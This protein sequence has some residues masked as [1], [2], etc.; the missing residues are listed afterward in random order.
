MASQKLG[1]WE[2]TDEEIE[3][4]LKASAKAGEA[5][6]DR[7][8][9]N[10]K[11]SANG[12]QVTLYFPDDLVLSFPSSDIKELADADPVEIRKGYLTE[13]GDA[14]H[15]DNL[16]AHYTVIGLLMG[17]FGPREW[18][19]EL[20][21]RGG[22]KT[23]AAKKLAAQINGAKGGRPRRRR[24]SAVHFSLSKSSSTSGPTRR[25]SASSA[26]M[27]TGKSPTSQKSSSTKHKSFTSRSRKSR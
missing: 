5:E 3:Q 2:F 24:V 14:I 17:R 18:M 13:D 25:S 23:S 16:D 15:W 21:K 10:I 12:K 19:R 6:D 11:F 7:P 22:S 27:S 9:S 20:A 26:R 1:K 4:Q 8:A